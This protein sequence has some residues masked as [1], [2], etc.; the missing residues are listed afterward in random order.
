[1]DQRRDYGVTGT[2]GSRGCSMFHEYLPGP[3]G[4]CDCCRPS[5]E[6]AAPAERWWAK[7]HVGAPPL[8]RGTKAWGDALN[9]WAEAGRPPIP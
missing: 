9:A 1:M 5:P 7:Q 6:E 8:V 4:F 2:R 3:D